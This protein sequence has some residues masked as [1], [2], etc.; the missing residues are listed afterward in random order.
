M[1]RPPIP[2]KNPYLAALLA[3]LVPGLG[4]VYQGRTRKGVL[5]ALCILGLFAVG[6]ILG[7]GHIVY[8]RW[9]NPLNNPEEFR[10]SYVCQF[11]TGLIALPGLIQATLREKGFDP[12]LWG[13]LAEPPINVVNAIQQRGKKA[14]I[15]LIYTMVAGLLNILAIYDAFEGPAIS[16]E[17]TPT[18]ASNSDDAPTPGTAPTVE[19]A[20]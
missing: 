1:S 3:W 10:F 12:V 16:S 5:Y 2:L 13:Y 7:G 14:E 18:P 20:V 11:F 8:W 4:H 9:L 6:M 19:A 15:G 17:P